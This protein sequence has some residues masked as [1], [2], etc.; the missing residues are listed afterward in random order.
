MPGTDKTRTAGDAV[1]ARGPQRVFLHLGPP[2]T[3]TTF[4]QSVLWSNK[5][6]LGRAG[7]L[8][9]GA[10]KAAHFDAV[11]DLRGTLRK[12]GRSGKA[13]AWDRLAA[14]VRAWPGTSVI[15]CEWLAF[16]NGDEAR[17][18]LGSF[19]DAEIHVVLTLRD[20]GRVVPA[21]WQEQIKNGKHGTMAS[22][23][24]RIS[25][26][27]EGYGAVF[28]R[29]HD[30][31][32]LLA[33]WGEELPPERLHVITVPTSGVPPDELWQR[34]SSLFVADGTGY[35]TSQ[36]RSNP[37]LAPAEAE[38]L[39]RV[40]AELRGRM[41]PLAHAKLVKRFLH[42]ELTRGAGGSKVRLPDEA[43]AWIASVAEDIDAALRQHGCDVVG[44][45]DDLKV[46]TSAVSSALPE[47]ADETD[48]SRAAVRS[49]AAM[50]LT[51]EA[52]GAHRR[53]IW[54]SPDERRDPKSGTAAQ[55]NGK[56]P[57]ASSLMLRARRAAGTVRRR[58]TPTA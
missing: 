58:L 56:S 31:R 14:E 15:S 13:G 53:Q 52:D 42:G 28:W 55:S 35:D 25:R 8:V 44:D 46:D 37:G 41:R 29:A 20:L 36:V 39:R 17:R 10:A 2:K 3:G 32:Q 43:I 38:L 4:V 27:D 11:G 57:D 12:A 24:E 40:N 6:E 9:P 50:L 1:Q 18:V 21:V 16:A 33:T 22:F 47:D 19:G 34:F 23:L 26:P 51:M 54:L 48:V 45:L 5:T 7:V 49:M 30:A